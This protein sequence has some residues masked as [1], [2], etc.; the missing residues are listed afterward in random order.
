MPVARMMTTDCTIV[1]R[2]V[3]DDDSFDQEAQPEEVEAVCSLQQRRR[4]ETDDR[5][6]VSETFWDLSL[7][8]GTEIDTGD[9]VKVGGRRYELVGEPWSPEE[10]SRSM[11]HVEATV[12]RVAGTED[13]AGS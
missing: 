12:R 2:S 3:V 5:G 11:W 13:E 4:D 1:R 10:G 8:H 7:P 6:E 9:A